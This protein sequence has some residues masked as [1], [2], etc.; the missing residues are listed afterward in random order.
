MLNMHCAA[1][2]LAPASFA[3]GV[4]EVVAT[5]AFHLYFRVDHTSCNIAITPYTRP[6]FLPSWSYSMNRS[7]NQTVSIK[8][9]QNSYI[10]S[11]SVNGSEIV[12]QS[13][14]K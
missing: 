4:G 6:S 7:M 11:R 12:G 8:L 2:H 9:Q 3:D 14:R 1:F 13:K 5:L 10:V